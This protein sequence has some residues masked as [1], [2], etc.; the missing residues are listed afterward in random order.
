MILIEISKRWKQT[1]VCLKGIML[2]IWRLGINSRIY[3]AENLYL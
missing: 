1:R 2:T 3:G